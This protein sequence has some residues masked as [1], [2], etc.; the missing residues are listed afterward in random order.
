MNMNMNSN[1]C[2]NC[3]N[4]KESYPKYI[5]INKKKYCYFCKL[6]YFIEHTDIFKIYIGY[7]VL[8]QDTIVK[9][10]KQFLLENNKMPTNKDIDIQSKLVQINPYILINVIKTMS[11]TE[12]ICFSNIKIFF[13]EDIDMDMIKVRR[14]IDKPKL[15]IKSNIIL[16]KIQLLPYQKVLYEKYINNFINDR[17]INSV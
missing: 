8:P 12:Q 17:S 15:L 14:I 7:S 3:N 9:K 11:Y 13:T 10:T 5:I 16:N 1:N 6:I 4:C 2:N